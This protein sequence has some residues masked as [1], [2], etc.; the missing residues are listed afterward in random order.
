MGR[1][2]KAAVFFFAV[3]W[4]AGCKKA[5]SIPETEVWN[6]ELQC[7]SFPGTAWGM[8]EKEWISF[9]NLTEKDYEMAAMEASD[10]EGRQTVVYNVLQPL[11]VWEYPAQLSLTFVSLDGSE[12]VLMRVEAVFSGEDEEAAVKRFQEEF[13]AN[14][15]GYNNVIS[16]PGK[17]RDLDADTAQKTYELAAS[18][19][20]SADMLDHFGMTS[21]TWTWDAETEEVKLTCEGAY[22]ALAHLAARHD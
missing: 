12:P 6:E 5:P 8:G 18:W 13:H 21:F 15:P 22:A 14:T 16:S 7:F 4:M 20:Y 10:E 1:C 9:W 17:V 3:L 2:L 11:A 19:G